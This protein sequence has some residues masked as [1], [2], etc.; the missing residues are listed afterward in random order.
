MYNMYRIYILM[1][2]NTKIGFLNAT[3]VIWTNV[4]CDIYIDDTNYGDLMQV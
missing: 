3:Q 1:G 2:R 4:V